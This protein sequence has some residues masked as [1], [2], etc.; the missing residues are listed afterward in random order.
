M[1][2]PSDGM[3]AEDIISEL[4]TLLTAGRLSESNRQ[5]IAAAYVSQEQDQGK[6]AALRLAQQL[7]AASPEYRTNGAIR[8][9]SD[10]EVRPQAASTPTCRPYKAIVF[11]MLQGG[12][13]SY[14]MLVPHSGCEERVNKDMYE[15]Y[16][17]VRQHLALDKDELL[18]IDANSA[19]QPCSRFGLHPQL[20]TLQNLYNEESAIF[21]ANVGS[22]MAI[23]DNR[24]YGH[25]Q[26]QTVCKQLDTGRNTTGTGVLGRLTDI[27]AKNGVATGAVSI[28]YISETLQGESNANTM[29]VS[30]KNIEQF[31]PKPSTDTF[32][33]AIET[34]N[35]ASSW[36]SSVFAETWST[37][38]RESID[39]NDVAYRSLESAEVLVEF[40]GSSIGKQLQTIARLI[41]S[42]KCRG[43]ERD[44]FY[45]SQGGY[46]HHYNVN[47][48][49]KKNF[50]DLDEA[51]AAF[52]SEL[53]EQDDFDD[54]VVVSSSEFGRTIIP[55]SRGGS[56][57]GWGGHA[58]LFGGSVKGG[59]ILG[60]YPSDISEDS[61][62]N[63]GRGRMMP[64]MG[65][66]SVWAGV[67]TW[68]GL[69]DE[70]LEEALP[71]SKYLDS[72]GTVS[73]K[74][75]SEDDLFVT[76]DDAN[77]ECTE[78]E[79]AAMCGLE[80]EEKK[81]NAQRVRRASALTKGDLH[82]GNENKSRKTKSYSILVF[83]A[84]VLGVAFGGVFYWKK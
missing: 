82:V 9:K 50:I 36:R 60:Q 28:N 44:V 54:V 62:L 64:T 47:R 24:L 10:D 83:V 1:Y 57:H 49:L 51:L 58:F 30:E 69:S 38:L 32:V 23:Y 43:V 34:L 80:E 15:E 56:D 7:I 59:Q 4:A 16:R 74:F 14:N 84:G 52:V 19:E 73:D 76:S 78:E 11:L 68:F 77:D 46:D 20:P 55:D 70:A 22:S 27:L 37:V 35:G 63:L 3:D 5:E 31:A 12:A 6:E 18:Q 65:W 2:Q 81:S 48:G 79:L 45:V 39:Q 53:K 21:M 42:R 13:D 40:P 67:A 41:S 17:E 75:Y 26:M 29:V 66:E 8:R 33:P 61:P 71:F 72:T 25:E